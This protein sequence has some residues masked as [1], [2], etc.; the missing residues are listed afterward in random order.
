MIF[1]SSI[2]YINYFLYFS[3][4]LRK[5]L[6]I[7]VL[8]VMIVINSYCIKESFEDLH[9]SQCRIKLE[10][11]P[12]LNITEAG[13]AYFQCEVLKVEFFLGLTTVGVLTQVILLL[14]SLGS[15]IWYISFRKISNI[16][17]TIIDCPQIRAE[18]KAMLGEKD[19][20]YWF[21]LDLIAQ[22][23]GMV[24]IFF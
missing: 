12:N 21:L 16:L 18:E 3:Y 9:P 20:D 8:F 13:V 11:V 19:R 6:E 17:K 24:K 7:I 1:V 4:I 5:A 14:C 10:E 23:S 15:L 22:S 2:L